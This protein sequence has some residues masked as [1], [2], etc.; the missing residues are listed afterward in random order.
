M[1]EY[2]DSFPVNI[3]ETNGPIVREPIG[4]LVHTMKIWENQYCIINR[5][6]DGVIKG[7]IVNDEMHIEL[8]HIDYSQYVLN[9]L[10]FRE[11]SFNKDRILWSNDLIIGGYSP[12]PNIPSFLSLFYQLGDLCKVQFSNQIYL[13][14]FYGSSSGYDLY[15]QIISNIKWKI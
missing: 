15:K 10:I 14:E 5:G 1:M 2:Y 13:I 12:A 3:L 6:I 9:K 7:N 8:E 4:F 11:I